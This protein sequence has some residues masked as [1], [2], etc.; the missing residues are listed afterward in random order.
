MIKSVFA[1]TMETGNQL[2]C[3]QVVLRGSATQQ[4]VTAVAR[5]VELQPDAQTWE[6]GE[7]EL[8]PKARAVAKATATQTTQG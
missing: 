5:E 4:V 7:W 8:A 2:S 3:D 6:S 1:E